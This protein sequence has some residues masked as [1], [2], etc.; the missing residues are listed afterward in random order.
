MIGYHISLIF[1]QVASNLGHKPQI[2][3]VVDIDIVH[4]T[5]GQHHCASSL[6]DCACGQ[7]TPASST[8]E[9]HEQGDE[10]AMW[11]V[12]RTDDMGSRYRILN[13]YT[14]RDTH[15]PVSECSRFPLRARRLRARALFPMEHFSWQHAQ[16]TQWVGTRRT[17]ERGE[18]LEEHCAYHSLVKFVFLV[19]G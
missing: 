11:R 4:I 2:H 15:R 6:H 14:L 17:G 16:G 7:C 13:L 19:T 3:L 5:G 18:G 1:Q 9:L 12:R 8:L 10:C